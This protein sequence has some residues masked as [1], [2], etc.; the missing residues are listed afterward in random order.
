MGKFEINLFLF[1]D[2]SSLLVAACDA[3]VQATDFCQV[4]VEPSTIS[5]TDN[6]NP[7][8]LNGSYNSSC[9]RS[10]SPQLGAEQFQSN[11]YRAEIARQEQEIQRLRVLVDFTRL[12]M[13]SEMRARILELRHVW[14]GEQ[15]AVIEA[16][17]KVWLQ[18]VTRLH[19]STKQK[20]WVS[21]TYWSRSIVLVIHSVTSQST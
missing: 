11:L 14:E 21:R 7:I 6:V 20:Q 4:N 17:G 15:L 18:E 8:C 5:S 9:T 12:E 10:S 13:A 16:A 19:E 3:A 1:L 2:Y